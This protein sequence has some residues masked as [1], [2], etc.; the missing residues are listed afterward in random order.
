VDSGFFSLS[1]VFFI[2]AK[3]SIFSIKKRGLQ[4]P[5]V[6]LGRQIGLKSWAIDSF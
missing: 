5:R 6:I 1:A 4:P 2:E 3:F